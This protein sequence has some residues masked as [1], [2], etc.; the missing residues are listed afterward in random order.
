VPLGLFS[1]SL[2]LTVAH[3][4]QPLRTIS[5]ERK[6]EKIDWVPHVFA[7][8][9]MI[10]AGLVRPKSDP[11]SI[12]PRVIGSFMVIVGNASIDGSGDCEPMQAEPGGIAKADEFEELPIECQRQVLACWRL[13]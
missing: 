3:P 11:K 8:V 10:L 6:G 12:Y 5:D 4:S 1:R 2:R 9:T 7:N 13:R